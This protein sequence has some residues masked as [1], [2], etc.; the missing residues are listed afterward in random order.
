[1]LKI[2]VAIDQANVEY[3]RMSTQRG[4]H[5]ISNV[6]PKIIIILNQMVDS[7]DKF[8]KKNNL[9]SPANDKLYKL[10]FPNVYGLSKSVDNL[11]LLRFVNILEHTYPYSYMHSYCKNCMCKYI[12]YLILTS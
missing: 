2:Y 6:I 5:N 4:A 7:T 12:A 3:S 9:Y 1:M 11:K 8:T 10:V